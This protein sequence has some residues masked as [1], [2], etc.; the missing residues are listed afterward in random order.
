MA[1]PD[2]VG[3]AADTPQDMGATLTGPFGNLSGEDLGRVDRA[4][5]S[6]APM[7]GHDLD[8]VDP[9]PPAGGPNDLGR[10]QAQ[11]AGKLMFMMEL[12]AMKQGTDGRQLTPPIAVGGNADSPVDTGSIGAAGPAATVDDL[13]RPDRAGAVRA[14][15]DPP[16]GFGALRAGLTE[17]LSGGFDPVPADRALPGEHKVKNDLTGDSGL[18]S[19]VSSVGRGGFVPLHNNYPIAK[20]YL[21]KEFFSPEPFPAIGVTGDNA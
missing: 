20:I 10:P 21:A 3:P 4:P 2:L 5:D 17:R 16:L 13:E 7:G 1:Q 18:E 19:G 12:E 14:K 6:V 8:G 11:D 15:Q 9:E